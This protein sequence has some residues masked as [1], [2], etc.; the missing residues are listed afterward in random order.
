MDAG[1]RRKFRGGESGFSVAGDGTA[2][3]LEDCKLDEGGAAEGETCEDGS[4]KG[5]MKKSEK[6]QG[7]A[8]VLTWPDVVGRESAFQRFAGAMQNELAEAWRAC[9]VFEWI[10]LG[11]MAL[12]S[13]LVA[14]FARNL[15]HPLRL[16]TTQ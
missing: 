6:L 7:N 15:A 12:S 16:V 1:E 13:V 8:A 10:A 11:Y 3:A 2:A 4:R 5:A 14:I 9:G